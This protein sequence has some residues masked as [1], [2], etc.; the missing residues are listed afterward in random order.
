M[1][2][3]TQTAFLFLPSLSGLDVTGCNGN[4]MCFRQDTIMRMFAAK[5]GLILSWGLTD[6]GDCHVRGLR[7]GSRRFFPAL[8]LCHRYLFFSTCS[9]T[10]AD[11]E[12]LKPSP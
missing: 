8:P 7:S 2:L 10:A 5:R 6:G 9:D 1:R 12:N 11:A 3:A 4:R